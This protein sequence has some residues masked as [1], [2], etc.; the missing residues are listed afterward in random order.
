M[1]TFYPKQIKAVSKMWCLGH[2]MRGVCMTEDF[3]IIQPRQSRSR[4]DIAKT[5]PK[6]KCHAHASVCVSVCAYHVQ[7]LY[8]FVHVE[9][10]GVYFVFWTQTHCGAP[11]HVTRHYHIDAVKL[12]LHKLGGIEIMMPCLV[13]RVRGEVRRE[14]ESQRQ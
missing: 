14:N 4:E 10:A 12:Q 3:F 7:E 9:P 6:R 11:H 5:K 8:Q 1:C 2:V 13:K